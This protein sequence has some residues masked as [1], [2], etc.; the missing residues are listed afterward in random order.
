M[1][2]WN[3]LEYNAT[4]TIL[5]IRKRQEFY[6]VYLFWNISIVTLILIQFRTALLW[7]V[8]MFGA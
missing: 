8:I 4:Q 5:E 1:Q 2:L 7:P 6:K 3:K